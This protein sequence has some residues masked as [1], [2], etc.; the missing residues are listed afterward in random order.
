[1]HS[2]VPN[3]ILAKQSYFYL[4]DKKKDFLKELLENNV[5]FED[6]IKAHIHLKNIWMDPLEWW[7]SE[8]IIEIKKRFHDLCFIKNDDYLNTWKNHFISELKK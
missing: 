3:I 4:S 6:P 1:M 5:L 8:K 2:G 7:N